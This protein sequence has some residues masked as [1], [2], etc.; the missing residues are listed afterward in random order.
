MGGFEDEGSSAAWDRAVVDRAGATAAP[1]RGILPESAS[2][3]VPNPIR[4]SGRRIR[5]AVD[6]ARFTETQALDVNMMG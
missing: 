1:S 5:V 3:P 4:R 6:R 2:F